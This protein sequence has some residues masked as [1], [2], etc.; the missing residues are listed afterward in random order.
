MRTLVAAM[1]F[2]GFG[3][4]AAAPALAG[5]ITIVPNPFSLTD[6]TTSGDLLLVDSV[7]GAPT[8]GS[9]FG[10]FPGVSGTDITLIFQL[11]ATSGAIESL[12]LSVLYSAFNG[13]SITDHGTIAG[14][15]EVTVTS[16]AAATYTT[17]FGD[18]AGFDF[19]SPGLNAAGDGSDDESDYFYVSFAS[20]VGDGSETVSLMVNPYTGADFSPSTPPVIQV[21][22][23]STI[24]LFAA[25]ALGIAGLTRRTNSRH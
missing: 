16:N 24:L 1:L 20:L 7:V 22:E 13:Y 23:A 25:G 21:P 14:T 19:G 12:G 6:G 11:T 3:L 9:S 2:A 5:P 10:F 17:A 8:G 15:G 4:T 18:S